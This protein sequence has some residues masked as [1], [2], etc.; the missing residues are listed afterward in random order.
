MAKSPQ[1]E[2]GYIAIANPIWE[3]IL[4]RRFTRDEL[5]VIWAVF[6]YSYGH[7]LKTA[8]ISR[9]KDFINFGVDP[10]RISQV[11]GRLVKANVIDDLGE[12]QY[13][14][15]KDYDFWAKDYNPSSEATGDPGIRIK[16][17]GK[18]ALERKRKDQEETT[19]NRNN[20]NYRKAEGLPTSGSSDF[21]HPEAGEHVSYPH[22][23]NHHEEEVPKSGSREKEADLAVYIHNK[24]LEFISISNQQRC[25]SI[26]AG[27]GSHEKAIKEAEGFITWFNKQNGKPATAGMIIRRLEN[28]LAETV[29]AVKDIQEP[30]DMMKFDV[31]DDTTWPETQK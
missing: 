3:E 24:T 14:F 21:Q 27:F 17:L 11:I 25:D 26:A 10:R 31:D 5:A 9:L 19:G 29:Q 8:K 12:G 4:Q 13:A 23:K 16:E 7:G 20:S 18:I 2:D 22:P 28:I 15:R 6:W 1:L 30:P